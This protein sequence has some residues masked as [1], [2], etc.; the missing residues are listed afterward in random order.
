MDLLY[1]FQC[2]ACGGQFYNQTEVSQQAA[3]RTITRCPVCGSKRIWST[4]REYPGVDTRATPQPER[5]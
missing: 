2:K 4:R 1:Q 5:D 3:A